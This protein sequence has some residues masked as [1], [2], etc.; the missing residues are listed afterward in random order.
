[1]GQGR[2]T[3]SS[4]GDTGVAGA[5]ARRAA[6]EARGWIVLRGVVAERDLAGLNRAFDALIGPADA[7]RG[8]IQ[9]PHAGRDDGT[10]LRHLHEGVAALAC[11]LLG[12]SSVQVLQD[13]LLLKPPARAG[14]IALHQ[15]YSYTAYLDRPSGLAVGLALN[16]ATADS[17]CLYV[18]D[19]SHAWG[20]VG[21]LHVFASGLEPDLEARLTPAQRARVS[22]ATIPLEVRAGDVTIHHCLTLHGSGGN[23]SARPRKTVI[24]HLVDGDSRVVRDRLPPG[25]EACFPVDGEGRLAATAFPA[26][27]A[28]PS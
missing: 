11:E 5:R 15:D 22:E 27:G 13:A 23:S 3:M 10:L 9:R 20:L 6:F 7:G 14:S 8:V 4:M 2:A 21:G 25:A 16:D 1:M 12:A 24:A 28:R 17:G 19:G 26:Y 18:V